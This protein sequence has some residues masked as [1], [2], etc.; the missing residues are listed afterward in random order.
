MTFYENSNFAFILVYV[1]FVEKTRG[2]SRKRRKS[3]LLELFHYFFE[4]CLHFFCGKL[5]VYVK[6]PYGDYSILHGS[7]FCSQSAAF[8]QGYLPFFAA[9]VHFPYTHCGVCLLEPFTL[10]KIFHP[11]VKAARKV[12]FS[13][14]IRVDEAQEIP[15]SCVCFFFVPTCI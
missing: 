7:F 14:V 13:R 15:Y 4:R 11:L 10:L 8:R 9:Y 3:F 5:G 12:I 1:H 6:F 2:N